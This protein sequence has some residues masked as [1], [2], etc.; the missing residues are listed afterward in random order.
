MGGI[1][2]KRMQERVLAQ[3]ILGGN[4]I[5]K[6]ILFYGGNNPNQEGSHQNT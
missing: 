6:V 1:H 4:G 2:M 5:N 3:G